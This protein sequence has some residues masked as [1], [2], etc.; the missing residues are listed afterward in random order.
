MGFLLEDVAKKQFGKK[1]E[2][3]INRKFKFEVN[4]LFQGSSPPRFWG[5]SQ[6]IPIVF[7][8]IPCN[9]MIEHQPLC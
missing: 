9:A 5:F 3:E 8:D 6:S 1:P 4:T 7:S 2:T